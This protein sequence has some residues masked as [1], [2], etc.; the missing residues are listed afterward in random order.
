[1][2]L[3]FNWIKTETEDTQVPVERWG[4]DK[5]VAVEVRGVGVIES[6]VGL[7]P[8][9]EDPIYQSA[10]VMVEKLEKPCWAAFHNSIG[11]AFPVLLQQLQA[12]AHI[13]HHP[14]S[15]THNKY[16]NFLY[17]QIL[18]GL[19]IC[20]YHCL[21]KTPVLVILRF[22]LQGKKKFLNQINVYNQYDVRYEQKRSYT[23]IIFRYLL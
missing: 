3:L 8:K 19:H 5:G 18:Q 22:Y 21:V 6:G 2:L 1:M 11:R 20:I 14:L 4:P 10:A 13:S 12:G 9:E 23:D 17:S 15:H 16:K 7:A